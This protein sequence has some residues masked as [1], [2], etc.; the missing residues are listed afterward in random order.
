[1]RNKIKMRL[2][3][4]M[5]FVA[6]GAGLAWQ[7]ALN[8]PLK[9]ELAEWRERNALRTARAHAAARV[10]ARAYEAAELRAKVAAL[11]KSRTYEDG[12]WLE[13]V[14]SLGPGDMAAALAALENGS[15]PRRN[16]WRNLLLAHWAS[17]NPRAALAYAQGLSGT[18]QMK[19]GDA[20]P[21]VRDEAVAAVLRVWAAKDLD[22]AVAWVGQLPAGAPRDEAVTG[23]ALAM[24]EKNPVDA[25]ALAQS[26]G[27]SRQRG[28]AMKTVFETWAETDVT[29]AAAAAANL[30]GGGFARDDACQGVARVWGETDPAAALAWAQPLANGAGSQV[31]NRWVVDDPVVVMDWELAQP[32]AHSQD[33]DLN[34]MAQIWAGYDPAAALQYFGNLPEGEQR[35][36]LIAQAVWSWGA[37]A[38][39]PAADYV[40]NLP[41][42]PERDAI[43]A[44][45]IDGW[46]QTN[47]TEAAAWAMANLEGAAQDAAIATVMRRWVPMEIEGLVE[48]SP[49]SAVDEGEWVAGLPA[50]H[51]QDAAW[52]QFFKD[53]GETNPEVAE[54]YLDEYAQGHPAESVAAMKKLVGKQ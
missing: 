13:L 11:L 43:A 17:L 4:G 45:L 25:V 50:G 19:Y 36:N 7:Y 32:A 34:Q 15:N 14:Y 28:F 44:K 48:R 16:D 22:A 42:G 49:G 12:P 9:R 6:A 21:S 5:L 53:V 23:V 29:A 3:L 41:A 39:Q 37:Q 31:M 52:S 40:A 38:G 24:A 33:D 26:V 1:M 54:V 18:A 51:M 30:A 20:W 2:G 10:N 8:A 46:A 35:N 47:P 27:E